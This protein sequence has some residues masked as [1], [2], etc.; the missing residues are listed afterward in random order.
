MLGIHKRVWVYDADT[1][2]VIRRWCTSGRDST[3][4]VGFEVAAGDVGPNNQL[5]NAGTYHTS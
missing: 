5:S 1:Y 3:P 4:K 2:D